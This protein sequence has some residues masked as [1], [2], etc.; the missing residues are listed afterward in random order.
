[1]NHMEALLQQQLQQ[2]QS[3]KYE[4]E[5]IEQIYLIFESDHP[6]SISPESQCSEIF[7]EQILHILS[8][9]NKTIGKY[10]SFVFILCLI[11]SCVSLSK[12]NFFKLICQRHPH[13]VII[14]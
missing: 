14:F 2:I 11:M 1:M 12:E 6:S 13:C 8:L 9:T 3:Q 10:I 7:H 4:M 5:L